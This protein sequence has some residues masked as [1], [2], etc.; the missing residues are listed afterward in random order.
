MRQLR[1]DK[2]VRH[3]S[4]G[5]YDNAPTS[6]ENLLCMKLCIVQIAHSVCVCVNQTG[7]QICFRFK[8]HV[9]GRVFASAT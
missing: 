2:M 7:K 6:R 3:V 5:F 1:F 9:G 4:A 8:C